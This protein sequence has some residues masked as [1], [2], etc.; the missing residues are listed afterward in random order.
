MVLDHMVQDQFGQSKGYSR[1]QLWE[2]QWS[3]CEFKDIDMSYDFKDRDM[4]YCNVKY[5]FQISEFMG[6]GGG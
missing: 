1:G 3:S 5:F 4:S 2:H 6:G